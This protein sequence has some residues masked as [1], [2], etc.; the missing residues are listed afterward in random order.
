MSE[1]WGKELAEAQAEVRALDLA[2][3]RLHLAK[4]DCAANMAIG[5]LPKHLRKPFLEI[6]LIAQNARRGLLDG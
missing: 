1:D 4:I 6:M 3:A 5:S 2:Y